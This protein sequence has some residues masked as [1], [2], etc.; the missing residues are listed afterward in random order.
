MNAQQST[1]PAHQQ[2]IHFWT[3]LLA[4]VLLAIALIVGA[5]GILALTAKSGTASPVFVPQT[6]NS[7]DHP[8]SVPVYV[9]HTSL[10]PAVVPRSFNSREHHRVALPVYVSHTSIAPVFV[11]QPIILHDRSEGIRLLGVPF[12]GGVAGPSQLPLAG[13]P[14]PGGVAGP[15]SVDGIHGMGGH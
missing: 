11:P 15:S 6:I 7:V 12:P 9:P 2:S 10:R 14:F 5:A 1:Y 3:P 8:A 4:A 13:V